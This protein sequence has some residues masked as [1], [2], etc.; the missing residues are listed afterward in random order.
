M[1]L[2]LSAL[3]ARGLAPPSV[4]R[5]FAAIAHAHKRAG[6]LAP[7]RT[8]GGAVVAEVLA[9]IRRSRTDAPPTKRAADADV[10]MQLL[11]AI[12]GSREQANGKPM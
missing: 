2:H 8:D 10:V 7:H 1:A 6:L 12:T 11:G 3:A 5:A 4:A 9:G